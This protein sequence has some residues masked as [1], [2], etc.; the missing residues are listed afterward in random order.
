MQHVHSQTIIMHIVFHQCHFSES[1]NHAHHNA[2]CLD[3]VLTWTV[4]CRS[5]LWVAN[6]VRMPGRIMEEVPT[7][8][9]RHEIDCTVPSWLY[10]L[11]RKPLC[12]HWKVS[13]KESLKPQSTL[14]AQLSTAHDLVQHSGQ[15]SEEQYLYR[16]EIHYL[17]PSSTATVA[18][19]L[20]HCFRA[21]RGCEHD[22]K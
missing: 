1:E 22:R 11:V 10:R 16:N 19:Q 15:K 2:Q 21:S 4:P 9:K 13:K 20:F 5:T 17:R 18:K 6:P 12:T 3:C 7:P 8:Y 14:I